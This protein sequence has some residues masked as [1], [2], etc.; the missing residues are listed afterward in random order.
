MDKMEIHYSDVYEHGGQSAVEDEAR[1][2]P[3]VKE[4]KHCK[5]CEAETPLHPIHHTC[6][7]CGQGGKDE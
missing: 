1:R 4:W 3:R 2:D 5:P 6:L 7:V